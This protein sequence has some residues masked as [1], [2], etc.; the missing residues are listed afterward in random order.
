MKSQLNIFS[1]PAEF[2]LT[3]NSLEGE[4]TNRSIY[5]LHMELAPY[6]YNLKEGNIVNCS[7]LDNQARSS[8]KIPIVID[9]KN[10]QTTLRS[11]LNEQL[12]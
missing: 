9:Y 6:G 5:D 8:S 1:I 7:P 3:N 2:P 4:R 11:L 10:P 12:A